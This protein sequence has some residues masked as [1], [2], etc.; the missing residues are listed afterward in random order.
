MAS[1]L[2]YCEMFVS[3]ILGVYLSLITKRDEE[4]QKCATGLTKEETPK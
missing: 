2:N 1:L 3:Y 4:P